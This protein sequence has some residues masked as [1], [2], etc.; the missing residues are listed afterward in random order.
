MILD[1]CVE[2]YV[3]LGISSQSLSLAYD[4]ASNTESDVLQSVRTVDEQDNL[5]YTRRSVIL[6]N[7]DTKRRCRRSA[8]DLGVGFLGE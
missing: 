4:R 3:Q 8:K 5:V 7:S 1:R 2:C 6:G